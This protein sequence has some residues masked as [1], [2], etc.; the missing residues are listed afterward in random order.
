MWHGAVRLCTHTSQLFQQHLPRV[1]F[2]AEI[3][4]STSP[5]II[6]SLGTSEHCSQST[7]DGTSFFLPPKP[8]PST[9]FAKHHRFINAMSTT[10][11]SQPEG[12]PQSCS[13]CGKTSAEIKQVVLEGFLES[14]ADTQD[15]NKKSF[16]W[17][18][19]CIL[20][21]K[22]MQTSGIKGR[23]YL[24]ADHFGPIMAKGKTARQA[25]IAF[26]QGK[27]KKPHPS[28]I[29]Y[30]D[31]AFY[32]VRYYVR[33]E[34]SKSSDSGKRGPLVGK[35]NICGKCVLECM[36]KVSLE[37]WESYP[38]ACQHWNKAESEPIQSEGVDL[39]YKNP[40]VF[41]SGCGVC[42]DICREIYDETRYHQYGDDFGTRML[43]PSEFEPRLK[44]SR[45]RHGADGI[46]SVDTLGIAIPKA[47]LPPHKNGIYGGTFCWS[48]QL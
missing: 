19:S 14:K 29:D 41:C 44:I 13:E 18:L 6:A 28:K 47:Y 10:T 24:K 45:A 17:E 39:H 8:L 43:T 22:T 37:W 48:I 7:V 23:N 42:H 38:M 15:R 12:A 1:F 11:I 40:E 32:L 46:G 2:V 35:W 31:V 33:K 16:L 30:G 34:F 36:E 5:V 25:F 3:K 26:W 9:F 21:G 20:D 27:Q 4:P